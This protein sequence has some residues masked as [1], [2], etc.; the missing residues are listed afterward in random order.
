MSFKDIFLLNVNS[1]SRSSKND[2]SAEMYPSEED[3]LIPGETNAKTSP[4][5]SLKNT[6]NDSIAKNKA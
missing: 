3:E 1:K 5:N 4:K 6:E 2:S